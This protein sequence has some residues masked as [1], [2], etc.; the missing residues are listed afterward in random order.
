MV[1]WILV[2]L[3]A[4]FVVACSGGDDGDGGDRDAT[5]APDYDGGPA[6]DG[7]PLADG[8]FRDGGPTPDGGTRDGGPVRDGGFVEGDCVELTGDTTI[9]IDLLPSHPRTG[10]FTS[11]QMVLPE[12]P[13]GRGLIFFRGRDTGAQPFT[14]LPPM[15]PSSY[16]LDLVED[17][18]DV[19]FV[20]TSCSVDAPPFCGRFDLAQGLEVSAAGTADF[21]LSRVSVT[22][23]VTASG[24]TLPDVAPSF[25][26]RI[27]LIA[28]NP[29]GF[30]RSAAIDLGQTGDLT[31]TVELA[32]GSY[33]VVFVGDAMNCD[34]ADLPCNVG[35][36]MQSVD[37]TAA[38]TLDIDLPVAIVTGELTQN[39]A[40]PSEAPF[41]RGQLVFAEPGLP[42]TYVDIV[43]QGPANYAASVLPGTYDVRFRGLNAG[44]V[45]T[46]PI[47]EGTVM[48]GVTIA[49]DQTL[50][51]DM[52]TARIG[53]LITVDG[54]GAVDVTP[55]ATRG[56]LVFVD[57]NVDAAVMNPA[58]VLGSTGPAR[59]DITILAGT[60]DIF[61]RPSACLPLLPCT[62][63]RLFTG[64]T[65]STD[66][67]LTLDLETHRLHGAITIDGAPY[68]DL[69][70]ERGNVTF[71]S[72][73]G[74]G[75]FP[76]G[77]SGSTY[78]VRVFSG[79]YA[80]VLEPPART[81]CLEG[82]TPGLP[83]SAAFFAERTVVT[84]TTLDLAVS[85]ADLS[86]VITVDGATLPAQG[87]G[88]LWAYAEGGQ[89][90]PYPVQSDGTFS[91]TLPHGRYDLEW[92][93][94]DVCN[95]TVDDPRPCA[96]H[97]VRRCR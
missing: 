49:A 93:P 62:S 41:I 19:D 65:I 80:V 29:M 95:Q 58:F 75:T 83:C 52:T 47:G 77:M 64:R 22:G 76:L 2:P 42:S 30:P 13:G 53:G 27:E 20:G 86:G 40:T 38:R 81:A 32:P 34:R 28:Q 78:D 48:N 56:E 79:D 60:Y 84:D 51:L 23:R 43:A 7:G 17:T 70:V 59:I 90:T 12:A 11:N 50:D 96:R 10:D 72:D 5:P 16:A 89:T 45:P 39:G 31:Y 44:T 85:T 4:L 33:D 92:A 61:Y 9:A 63:G 57:P 6:P 36:V 67:T 74:L 66:E 15:G 46:L 37:L 3:F 54:A 68:P 1:R 88:I 87:N 35:V 55:P 97:Y 14:F 25:R 82:S 21:E 18:Y 94:G 73:G 26:G 71:I 91:I 69:A 8:G 24:A